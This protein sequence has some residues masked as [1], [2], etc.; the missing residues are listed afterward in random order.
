[1]SILLAAHFPVKGST[2]IWHHPHTYRILYYVLRRNLRG[3]NPK[4][5]KRSPSRS[6]H[7]APPPNSNHPKAQPPRRVSTPSTIR[8]RRRPF[9][10][11][12]QATARSHEKYAH[13]PPPAVGN[14]CRQPT[15]RHGLKEN[16]RSI[17][18][19][20]FLGFKPET[21]D[22][23]GTQSSPDKFELHLKKPEQESTNANNQVEYGRPRGPTRSDDVAEGASPFDRRHY[24]R[25]RNATAPTS[26]PPNVIQSINHGNRN[27]QLL[28]ATT[29]PKR[30]NCQDD[31][32]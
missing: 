30:H 5:V 16:S 19:R 18:Q 29:H 12:R 28:Q 21:N 6:A 7:P 1:M 32:T 9:E 22:R 23:Q 2:H 26:T 8:R 27:S 25:R 20:P 31:P 15:N 11:G 24:F 10:I 17:R 13:T 14:H 4:T 3:K